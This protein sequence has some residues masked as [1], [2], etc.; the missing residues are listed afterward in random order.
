MIQSP[1][2]AEKKRNKLRERQNEIGRERKK[3][4]RGQETDTGIKTVRPDLGNET[5][6]KSQFSL[7]FNYALASCFARSSD[8]DAEPINI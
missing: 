3:S 5:F 6:G 7:G 8:V 2:E 1:R 4:K